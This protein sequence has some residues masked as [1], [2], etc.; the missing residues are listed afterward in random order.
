[1]LGCYIGVAT[2]KEGATFDSLREDFLFF[3]CNV[4]EASTLWLKTLDLATSIL[5][6]GLNMLVE[7][8]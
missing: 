8:F 5:F 3:F 6:C 7:E 2:T 4:N 1:M